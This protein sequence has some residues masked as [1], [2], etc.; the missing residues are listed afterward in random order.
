MGASSDSDKKKKK[1]AKEWSD[2]FFKIFDVAHNGD[3]DFNEFKK[4]CQ[5]INI[6]WK[7]LFA[8]VFKKKEEDASKEKAD[9]KVVIDAKTDSV[10]KEEEVQ[11]DDKNKKNDE[12]EKKENLNVDKD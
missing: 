10:K 3:L 7:A 9:D 6:Q 8:E 2:K 4:G 11:S 1:Q 12:I 5:T